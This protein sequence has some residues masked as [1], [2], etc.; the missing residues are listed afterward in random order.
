MVGRPRF[1]TLFLYVC[2]PFLFRLGSSTSKLAATWS[3]PSNEE[4]RPPN[5]NVDGFREGVWVLA[6]WKISVETY[7]MG[8]PQGM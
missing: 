1:T 4:C 5:V 3:L 6:G 2:Q 8:R 7:G